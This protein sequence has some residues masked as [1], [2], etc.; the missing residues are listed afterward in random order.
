[1]GNWHT[2]SQ[3]KMLSLLHTEFVISVLGWRR[4]D[5]KSVVEYWQGTYRGAR[6][7][8]HKRGNGVRSGG[9]RRW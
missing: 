7:A 3:L 6:Q 2:A 5:G 4:G 1:M 9:V 8:L